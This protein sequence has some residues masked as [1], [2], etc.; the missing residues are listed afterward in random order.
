VDPFYAIAFI[1][2]FAL[3][4]MSNSMAFTY[5]GK[6][7]MNIGLIHT[8]FSTRLFH[9]FIYDKIHYTVLMYIGLIAVS[10]VVSHVVEWL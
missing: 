4:P 5:L 8:W 2:L 6:H 3:L 10:L 9:D 7:S 1:V